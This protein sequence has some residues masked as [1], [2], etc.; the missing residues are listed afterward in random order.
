MELIIN[1]T[2]KKMKDIRQK[3]RSSIRRDNEPDQDSSHRGRL[4]GGL[5]EIRT[6]LHERQA[7]RKVFFN[8]PNGSFVWTLIARRILNEKT[9][10]FRTRCGHR[11]GGIIKTYNPMGKTVKL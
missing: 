7:H 11:T 9:F 5:T 6:S 3:Q 8:Q 10:H 2:S 1:R 4:E